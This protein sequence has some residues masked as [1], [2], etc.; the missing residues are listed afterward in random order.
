MNRKNQITWKLGFI[1]MG[2]LCV[3]LA[4]IFLSM[5]R[6]NYQEI[7]KAAGIELY[8]CANITT[9]LVSPSD[10]NQAKAGDDQIA[11]D[12]GEQISWTVHHK[13]IFEGQYLL[14]FDGT[15]L[16]TDENLQKQGFRPGDSFYVDEDIMKE[17]QETK[18]P[19]YSDVYEFGGMERLTGYA[20]IFEDHDP[21]KNIVAVSAIDFESSILHERTW[22]MVKGSFLFAIFPIL[23]AGVFTIILIK[24]TT[25]PLSDVIRFASRVA[26][27]DLSVSHLKI[28][29]KD[30]IGELSSDLN[31]MRDNLVSIIGEVSENSSHVATASEQLSASAEEISATAEQNVSA[32]QEV[33]ERTHKQSDIVLRTNQILANLSSK[34]EGMSEKAQELNQKSFHTKESA[35]VGYEMIQESMGQM[36]V[37]NEKANNLKE[38]MSTLTHKSNEIE[39]IIAMITQIS[40]QTNLLALNAAI[41]ASHAGEHGKGFAVVADEVRHLAEQSAKATQQ[42]SQL[43]HDIQAD[44]SQAMAE[45][46]ESTTAMEEGTT[47]IDKA[48]N[49][50]YEI[51]TSVQDVTQE[52]HDIYQDITNVTEGIKE[53]VEAMDTIEHLSTTNNESTLRVLSQ[54]E[55][56]AAAI[57]EITSLMETLSLQAEELDNKTKRFKL[58]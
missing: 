20:P 13:D 19:V 24:R 23:L 52:I 6:T 42:I 40:N 31:T 48:G 57:E 21:S 22:N 51:N 27:G 36:R 41:E 17:L 7:K 18:S 3:S 16:A 15:L 43:I 54:T 37:V 14:D 30:E 46:Q 5:Y 2:I 12:L 25:D 33:K 55:D 8:G 38:S 45:T 4:I 49:T 11:A 9:A 10:I 32:T 29:R 47:M 50:F 1:I 28:K 34:N 39:E 35:E 56:Q 53:V 58:A 26:D 44:T